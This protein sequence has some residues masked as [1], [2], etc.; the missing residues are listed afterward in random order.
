MINE[1]IVDKVLV[2]FKVGLE[3]KRKRKMDVSKIIRYIEDCFSD[4]NCIFNKLKML[5]VDF[6]E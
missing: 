6:L 5:E 3:K 4:F 1:D 2:Y